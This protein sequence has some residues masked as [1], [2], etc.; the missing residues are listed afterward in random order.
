MQAEAFKLVY[1]RGVEKREIFLDK[2]D[3]TVFLHYLKMYLS[4]VEEL[5][6][7]ATPNFRI[8]RFIPQNLSK[9]LDLLSFSLMPNHI[10]LQIKQH[11]KDAITKFIRRLLTSYVMYFNKKNQRVGPLF[12]NRYKAILIDNESFLLHLSRYIHLNPLSVHSVID[13]LDFSSYPYYLNKKQA[14]WVKPQEILGY[15]K[16]SIH[17]DIKDMLSYQSFVEDCQEEAKD[18]LGNLTLEDDFC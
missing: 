10:H 11:T 12:Q 3:C 16:S 8:N 18:I 7:I 9:E 4:P 1:N 15:F 14:S 17:K 6:K 2:Q 13:F 5:K